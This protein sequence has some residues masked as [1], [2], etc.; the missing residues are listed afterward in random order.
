MHY[1]I[2]ARKWRPNSFSEIIGQQYILTAIKNGFLFNKIHQSWILSGTR[3]TGKTTFARLLS[4]SLNC[5][6]GIKMYP[7][8][9]CSNCKDIQKGCFPDL[10][11]IDAAS[12]T[13]VEDI[14]ELLNTV[15]Y[16]PTKGKFK[17]Y[18]IDEVHMLSKYSFN[19]LLKNLEEPP[20]YVKF[21][22]ATTEIRKLPKTIISRCIY[23]NFKEIS[24]IQIIE[25]LSNILNKEKIVF[26]KK[27]LKIIAKESQGSIRDALNLSEQAIMIGGNEIKESILTNI[28]NFLSKEQALKIIISVFEKNTFNV[29]LLLTK[30]YKTNIELSTILTK[31]LEILHNI[32]IFKK[33]F[34]NDNYIESLYQKKLLKIS[35]L[36]DYEDLRNY[37]KIIVSGIKELKFLPNPKIG[38]EITLLNIL[39]I[40]QKKN[41]F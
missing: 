10:I 18:L 20:K 39:S 1:Q 21:I 32:I 24:I 14:K 4:K 6:T 2:L 16:K 22:L 3:G 29:M 19:A 38:I 31:I 7:C 27:A 34:K 33:C 30:I 11:E 5:N 26:E 40:T 37:Y 17:I 15:K 9:I 12:K 8:Q 25:H 28:F 13:K 23:F 41:K 35:K 36:I